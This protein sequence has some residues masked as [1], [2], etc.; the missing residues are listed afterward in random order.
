MSFD[1]ILPTLI[2]RL[3]A[4]AFRKC[5]VRDVKGRVHLVVAEDARSIEVQ[6]LQEKLGAYFVGPVLSAKAA[7]AEGRLA[8]K[9]L[10]TAG[11]K[12][13]PGWPKSMPSPLGEQVDIDLTHWSGIER[14]IGKDA[15]F[16]Q[17]AP[18]WPIEAAPA[19]ITFHSFKGGVGRTTLLA[20]HAVAFA[21]K[22]VAV[23][24]LDLEAPGLGALFGVDTKRGLLDVL[25]DH[26]ATGELNLD[27]CSAPWSL[28]ENV[29]VFPAGRVDE[30]YLHK[31][32]RL[33]F[34]AS[35]P[36]TDNPVGVALLSLLKKIR[37]DFDVILL[38]A[39]AGLHDIAGMSLHG[40]AHLN[41]LVF[42]G[43]KQHLAGL[44][45]TLRTLGAS[46]CELLLVESLLPA[47][48]KELFA[49]RRSRSREAVYDLLMQHVYGDEPPQLLDV[50]ALHEA[51]TIRRSE[52]FDAV[53]VLDE[54]IVDQMRRDPDMSQLRRRIE[55][56]FEDVADEDD[57]EDT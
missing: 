7:G 38:D 11:N 15:W 57:D 40:L 30:N 47:G 12:W 13:P 50:G 52:A 44:G 53:D 55:E 21:S 51:V 36:G 54:G 28:G 16:S 43:T 23:I 42:R 6:A 24:D 46:K 3:Q 45:E 18:P 8:K 29:R 49:V 33:D 2:E 27:D 56:H 48:D 32:A 26:I 39:R 1:R 35:E 25:V 14:T 41:V 22:R 9:V 34:C 10:E 37:G 20:S 4:H 5:I 17:A 31:L 19:I